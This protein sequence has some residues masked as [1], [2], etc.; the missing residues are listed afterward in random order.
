VLTSGA[1]TEH[2]LEGT[3]GTIVVHMPLVKQILSKVLTDTKHGRRPPPV[4]YECRTIKGA[5]VLWYL[6]SLV[7]YRI[8]PHYTFG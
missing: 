6:S 4:Q 7:H 8:I 1:G 5:L 3:S 2:L